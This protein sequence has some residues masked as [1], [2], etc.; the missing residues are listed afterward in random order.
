MDNLF[1]DG[2]PKWRKSSSE[3]GFFST[4]IISGSLYGPPLASV[5]SLASVSVPRSPAFA[6]SL[7]FLGPPG[8]VW[9]RA[10]GSATLARGSLADEDLA[11]G[12]PVERSPLKVPIALDDPKS[13]VGDHRLELGG[14]ILSLGQVDD[15]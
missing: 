1:L 9:P 3:K 11:L 5:R 6:G 15:A 12:R 13:G 2:D 14:K 10:Q 8:S 7:H 4:M